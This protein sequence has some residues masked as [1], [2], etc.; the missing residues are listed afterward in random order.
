MSGLRAGWRSM[1]FVYG[2]A[3]VAVAFVLVS[4]VPV[5]PHDFWWYVRLGQEIVAGG[6]IPAVDTFSW[7]RRGAPI[8]YHSWLGAVL[9]YALHRWGGLPAVVAANAL[10]VALFFGIAYWAAWRAAGTHRVAAPAT[11]VGLLMSSNNWAVR[12]QTFALPLFALVLAACWPLA[13]GRAGARRLRWWLPPLAALW[14]NLHGSFVLALAVVGAVWAGELGRAAAD[15]WRARREGASRAGVWDTFARGAVAELTL[16]TG[17]IL[18]ATL[19]NPRGVG[20]WAYVVRLLTDPP[21]QAFIVEWQPPRPT[22]PQGGLFFASLVGLF[23]A[24]AWARRRPRP[25]EL[26]VLALFAGMGLTSTR[27]VIWY[28]A[29]WP[30]VVA[31]LWP[32]PSARQQRTAF[33]PLPHAVTLASLFLLPLAVNPWTKARLPLPAKVAD[34]VTPDT[35]VAAAEWLRRH[36]EGGPLFNEMGYGS[37]LIWAVPEVP[38]FVDTRVEL[39]PLELWEEYAAISGA[40]YDYEALLARRGVGRVMADAVRQAPLVAALRANPRWEVR[41][42]DGRTIV[43]EVKP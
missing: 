14:V 12:P 29:V 36:P 17:L 39:Y 9:L 1:G 25:A 15:V 8:V 18:L 7:T 24:L 35:P 20:A 33:R 2:V 27:Y 10:S 32:T 3:I 6:A 4:L 40:R 5:P 31:G 11:A 37:Y 30:L 41:Y 16:L 42:D 21:S 19:A 38:V 22:T 13:R 23:F 43:A 28:A 34:L 26:V